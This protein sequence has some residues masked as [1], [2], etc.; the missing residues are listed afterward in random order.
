MT[1]QVFGAGKTAEQP[2]RPVFEAMKRGATGHCPR[3]G[4]GKLFKGYVKTVDSCA[5]CSEDISHHRA[6]DLPAYLVVLITGHIV[7]GSFMAFEA[8]STLSML[9]HM[10]IWI[11]LTIVSAGLLLRPVKGAVVGLQWALY[12]HG[13]G[14]EEDAPED[15]PGEYRA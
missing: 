3:C 13:F 12:M 6:D 4:S 11:P 2:K 15:A 8:V 1:Q 14:G 7:V 5:V 9:Q 10:A